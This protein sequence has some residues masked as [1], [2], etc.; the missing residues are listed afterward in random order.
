MSRNHPYTQR[1]FNHFEE[2]IAMSSFSETVDSIVA[3]FPDYPSEAYHFIRNGLDFTVKRLHSDAA[4]PP[5]HVSGRQL[6]E[7]L[8]DYALQE[9]GPMASFTLASWNLRSTEDF[10]VI[11]YKLIDAGLLAQ[12]PDD[13]IEDFS[14]LFSLAA[15]LAEP[16]L[17]YGDGQ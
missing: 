3:A 13:S 5:R 9:F 10:G 8:R 4:G 15:A 11:V 14:S 7:G 16:Y 17:G 2:T 1:I 6:A 12:S